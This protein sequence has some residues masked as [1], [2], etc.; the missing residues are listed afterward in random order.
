MFYQTL[1][2]VDNLK[3]KINKLNKYLNFKFYKFKI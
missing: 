1:Y 2:F 3:I